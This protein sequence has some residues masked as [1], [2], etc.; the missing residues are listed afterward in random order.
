MSVYFGSIPTKSF[1]FS[2]QPP[3]VQSVLVSWLDFLVY[4][5][6]PYLNA[7]IYVI[8]EKIVEAQ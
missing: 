3:L 7:W 8:L 5:A 1:L 6:H 2:N 4:H